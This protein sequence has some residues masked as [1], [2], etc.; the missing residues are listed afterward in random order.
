TGPRALDDAVLAERDE[1]DVRRV[2]KHGDEDVALPRDL[3]RRR[4]PLRARS[5]Q[6]VHGSSTAI[7]DNQWV[8]GLQKISGHRSA[9]DPEANESDRL[10][11]DPLAHADTPG[12]LGTDR[13]GP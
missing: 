6:L 8:T 5:H 12:I 3:A 13:A 1:L 4:R 9:H 11:H 2:R 10:R 7:V